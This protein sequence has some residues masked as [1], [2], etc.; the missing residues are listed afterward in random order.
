MKHMHWVFWKLAKDR[1]NVGFARPCFARILTFE[2]GLGCPGAAI[3]GS[4]IED[5]LVILPKAFKYT[6]G[7]SPVPLRF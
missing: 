3:L 7:L 5:C 1:S 6:T 4:V 2:N